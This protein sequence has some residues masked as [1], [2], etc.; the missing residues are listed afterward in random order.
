MGLVEDYAYGRLVFD[1]AEGDGGILGGL[2]EDAVYVLSGAEG[3]VGAAAADGGYYVED[4]DLCVY[5]AGH[6]CG[7]V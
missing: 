2:M 1:D 4:G 7:E 6:A 3:L 5:A